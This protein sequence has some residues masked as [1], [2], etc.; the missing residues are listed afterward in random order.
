MRWQTA[1]ELAENVLQIVRESECRQ[2]R[3]TCVGNGNFGY[4]ER[5][6]G[7]G[8]DPEH[9]RYIGTI[10]SKLHDGHDREVLLLALEALRN[11]SRDLLDYIEDWVPEEVPVASLLLVRE[12]LGLANGALAENDQIIALIEAAE[13]EACARSA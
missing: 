1:E 9:P 6:G 4:C 5:C 8:V 12:A 11:A 10:A 13:E 2:C 3:G 7:V